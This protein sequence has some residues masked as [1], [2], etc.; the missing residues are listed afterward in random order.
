M[1]ARSPPPI[2]YGCFT[3]PLLRLRGYA[4]GWVRGLGRV[5]AVAFVL[6]L[7]VAFRYYWYFARRFSHS[8]ISLF[9]FIR[10]IPANDRRRCKRLIAI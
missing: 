6:G 2:C 9:A 4:I 10:A 1:I 7:S 5:V 8:I 3:G